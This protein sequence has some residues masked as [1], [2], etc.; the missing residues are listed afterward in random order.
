MPVLH[1]TSSNSNNLCG[2]ALLAILLLSRVVP[3]GSG[4]APKD[5]DEGGQCIS[6]GSCESGGHCN[7]DSLGCNYDNICV[8]LAQQPAAPPPTPSPCDALLGQTNC[9]DGWTKSCRGS[10]TP[11]PAWNGACIAEASDGDAAT[12]FCCDEGQPM[13]GSGIGTLR[14]VPANTIN[15]SNCPGETYVCHYLS[16]PPIPD[17][18]IQCA[19]DLPDDAGWAPCC[20][21]SGDSCFALE[22]MWGSATESYFPRGACAPGEE[23]HFCTGNATLP[24]GPCRGV[25]APEGGVSP[26]QPRAF[27]CP[28]GYVPL[29]SDVDSGAGLDAEET[30]D[31]TD[32]A[33]D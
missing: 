11:D 32:D 33:S 18:S 3:F 5:G 23:E 13:C 25:T 29:G 1:R 24:P 15:W 12:V 28:Q 30:E 8:K 20:C 2:K 10:S 26:T 7:D 31:A 21:V 19:V 17:A 22:V 6:N 16:A 9:P 27:C 4:C 14:P